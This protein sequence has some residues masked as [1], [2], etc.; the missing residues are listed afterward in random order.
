MVGISKKALYKTSQIQTGAETS[1]ASASSA[2]LFN[3]LKLT[4]ATFLAKA[5]LGFWSE[6]GK[7]LEDALV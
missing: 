7:I 1:S 4:F 6:E 3:S 5:S 2:I